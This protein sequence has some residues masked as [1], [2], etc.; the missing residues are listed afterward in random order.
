MKEL[1]TEKKSEVSQ[2]RARAKTTP[3]KRAEHAFPEGYLSQGFQPPEKF[4]PLVTKLS[5]PA[6]TVQRAQILT[7]IQQTY[8]N[9]YVQRAVSAFRSKNIKEDDGKLTSQILSQKGSGRALK[10]EIREFMEPRFGRDFSDV[11]IHTDSFAERAA[12]NLGAEAFTTGRDIFFGEGKYNPNST[13][14]K[15][16]LAHELTHTIQQ[17][18]GQPSSETIHRQAEEEE[19]EEEE[20]MH[21]FSRR[22]G[23]Q[24]KWKISSPDDVY[25]R[26]ADAIADMVIR[27]SESP[28]VS[29]GADQSNET[30]RSNQAA[31]L[32]MV[33]T[34]HIPETGAK[35]TIQ[36][37]APEVGIAAVALGYVIIHDAIA[38]AEGDVSWT[39]D[40]MEGKMSPNDDKSYETRGAFRPGSFWSE[41][42]WENY[43]GDEISLRYEVNYEYN[44]FCV[45]NVFPQTTRTN[46]AVGWGLNVEIEVMPVAQVFTGASG[47]MAAVDIYHHYRFTRIIGSDHINIQR[48]RLFG[49]GSRQTIRDEWTQ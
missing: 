37:V 1:K 31:M 7:R 10:P 30:E 41:T 4:A 24:G 47:P 39:F 46:D 29:T 13:Q 27:Q 6:N 44:G 26:E 33:D 32:K 43:L 40:K 25:E 42:G 35:E 45:A 38:S 8:G 34:E 2:T 3:E 18:E 17:G 19:E 5:H 49:D 11:K 15:R 14:G 36:R 12:Q 28:A 23:I 21:A 16:L 20:E 48:V 22:E 9:K